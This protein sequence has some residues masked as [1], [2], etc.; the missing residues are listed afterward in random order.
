[1]SERQPNCS[2]C[3]RHKDDVSVLMDGPGVMICDICVKSCTVELAD[4]NA[5]ETTEPHKECSFCSF[6]QNMPFIQPLGQEGRRL[7]RGL[8][9]S[10]CDD[11]LNTCNEAIQE[12]LNDES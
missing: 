8:T 11:C 2:F 3:G 6:L 4:P 10:I 12:C 1:M 5:G 7:F 9:H